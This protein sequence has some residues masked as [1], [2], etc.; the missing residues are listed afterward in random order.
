L[1]AFFPM[2]INTLAGVRSIQPVYFDVARNYGASGLLTLRRVVLPGSL[3]SIFSGL[4]LAFNLTLLLTI[5]VEMISATGGLGWLVWRAWQ[6]MRTEEV[7]VSLAVIMLLGVGSN[8]V[9]RALYWW[10]APWQVERPWRRR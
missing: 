2:V 7:Y 1:A 5:A 4:L 10:L 3:P 9:L 6:V 8:G